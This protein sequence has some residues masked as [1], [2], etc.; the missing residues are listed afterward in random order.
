MHVV[1]FTDD[2]EGPV[3]GLDECALAKA[4][5]VEGRLLVRI[6]LTACLEDHIERCLGGAAEPLE[7]A[8]RHDLAQPRLA[9]LCAEGRR[10]GSQWQGSEGVGEAKSAVKDATNK[11][12]AAIN[13]NF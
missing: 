12:A 3:S 8:T 7:P 6:T 4:L 11:T 5:D 10:A 1:P 2:A 9:G 13:K